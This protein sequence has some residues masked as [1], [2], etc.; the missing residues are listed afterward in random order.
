VLIILEGGK[1]MQRFVL[2]ATGR[3]GV[4][5]NAALASSKSWVP[6]EGDK[7]EKAI[8]YSLL[9]TLSQDQLV[10]SEKVVPWYLR[11]LPRSYFNEIGESTRMEHLKG[12]AALWGINEY[13]SDVSLTLR[14]Q[15]DDG[16]SDVTVLRTDNKVGVLY[17]MLSS[18]RPEEAAKSLEKIRAYTSINGKL[19]LNIISYGS[20]ESSVTSATEEDGQRILD[21]IA[22]S[23]L[24]AD[25]A[26]NAELFTREAL[27]DFFRLCRP[28]LVRHTSTSRFAVLRQLYGAVRG[29]EDVTVRIDPS[30]QGAWIAIGAGSG[31][32]QHLVLKIT[33]LLSSQGID[34][35]RLNLDKIQDPS[36]Y[37]GDQMGSVSLIRVLVRPAA[38]SELKKGMMPF[39]GT[40]ENLDSDAWNTLRND[41][42]RVRWLDE[43]TLDLAMEKCPG[44][45]L[46]RAEILTAFCAMLHGP[47]SKLSPFAF[48]RANLPLVVSSPLYVQYFSDVADLFM[49][50]FDPAKPLTTAEFA[51]RASA[52]RERIS[53]LANE[54][55]RTLL[56]KM[57][58]AVEFTLRTNLYFKNRHGLA[59]RVDGS[60]M[61]SPTQAKPFGVF[62]VHG[63]SFNG[64]HNRFQNIARGGLRLVTPGS[65]EQLAVE[66]ANCYD[67]VYGLSSAQELKNKDIPEGGSK[68]VCLIDTTKSESAHNR[69][70][71]M[72]NSVKAFVDSILDLTVHTE[73]TR[74]SRVDYLGFDE[75]IYLGPDEQ[76]VPEDINWIIKQAG[77]RGYPIPSAFMSSKPL[78]GINHKEYGVTSEGVVVFLDVALRQNG[79][80]PHKDPFTVKITGG[81]DGDVAGN[82]MRILKRDY[83]E[84]ARIVGVADGSGCAEDPEG[85][86]Y[87]EL[88]RLFHAALPIADIDASKL[89]HVGTVHRV[90]TE[91]GVRM[92]NSMHFRVKSDVFVPAG[93]RPHTIHAGNWESFLDPD[94]GKPSSPLIVEGANIFITPEARQ[95]FYEKAGVQLVKD[96]SANKCGVITSSYE[97][98]ASM[99]LSEEEFLAIKGELVEDVLQRLR[100]LA[101]LE[102][103][104][105]FREFKNYPGALPH[106]SERLSQAIIRTSNVLRESLADVQRGDDLYKKL[107]PLFLEDHLPRKLAEV[108]GDRVDERIPIDYLRNAFASSLASKLLYSEGINF[109][110]SQPEDKLFP[111]ALRYME[112][113]KKI[114]DLVRTIREADDFQEPDKSNVIDLL[115]RGGVRS[116]LQM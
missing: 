3:G 54:T 97:I 24:L 16:L 30:D 48:S 64:F 77:K 1:D 85:L 33:N 80:D 78:A 42:L 59:F 51:E 7:L 21:E 53:V 76:V 104:L 34:V 61:V 40:L 62:F 102:A 35:M 27:V 68:A 84:N 12:L 96:S 8:V 17:H 9:H 63:S 10:V 4:R 2:A 37:S 32:P 100:E 69:Y 19:T 103:D 108:A 65:L 74:K 18:M 81:P 116:S 114:H 70:L 73:E 29:T 44:I 60:L 98:C 95:Q 111:F 52:L 6:K 110:E 20:S 58:D 5:R 107:M 36:N 71:T 39:P 55:A 82:L 92:R 43:A 45:G 14:S 25:R 90:G 46:Q 23:S 101:R 56:L 106:F 113:E 15:N 22:G 66:S 38:A 67:E 31:N 91:E 105:L 28:S 75:L 112:E 26:F 115:R 47:L 88:L 93:G 94:T 86:P 83:G 50:R 49:A 41:I 72:R 13:S 57:V 11:N 87:D 89:S 99:L 79:I 109:L